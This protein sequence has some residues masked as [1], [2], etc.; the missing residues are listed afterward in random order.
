MILSKIKAVVERPNLWTVQVNGIE[1]KPEKGKWWLDRSF[2]VFNIGKI[3]KPGENTITLKTSPMKI[4]AEIEP[5]YIARGFL[6]KT[7]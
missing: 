7:C 5:V 6:C 4:N 2:G 3:V 1:V